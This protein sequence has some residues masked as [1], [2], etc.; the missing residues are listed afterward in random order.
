VQK[1]SE[2]TLLNFKTNPCNSTFICA[3]SEALVSN[4]Q[5]IKCLAQESIKKWHLKS[6]LSKY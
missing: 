6:C 2:K 4:N 3:K 1:K 5:T